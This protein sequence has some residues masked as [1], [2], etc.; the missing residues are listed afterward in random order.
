MGFNTWN[1]FNCNPTES[2]IRAIA[3]AMVS[4]GLASAGYT[5]V[6]ID[7]CYSLKDRNSDGYIVEDPAKFP[8]GMR[9]LADYIHSKQLKFGM[10]T[11]EGTQTCAGFPGI[12]N[13]EKID[14]DL[15]IN[16]WTID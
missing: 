7:D 11:S 13:N 1:K 9:A 2:K 10:Y 16:K 8:S 12:L 6:N 14:S 15:F 3:D 4:L 5:Y